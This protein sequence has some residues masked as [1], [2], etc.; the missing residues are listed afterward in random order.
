VKD[1]RDMM[2]AAEVHHARYLRREYKKAIDD[3]VHLRATTDALKYQHKHSLRHI[4]WA[5]GYQRL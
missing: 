3:L 1:E 4:A 2:L 5:D